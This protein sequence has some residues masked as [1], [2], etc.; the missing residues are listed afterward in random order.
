MPSTKIN[1]LFSGRTGGSYSAELRSA[2]AMG[3]IF[4]AESYPLAIK[5]CNKI[6]GLFCRDGVVFNGFNSDV[7]RFT[8]YSLLKFDVFAERFCRL[9]VTVMVEE[10][11]GE[12]AEYSYILEQN[13]AVIW[14]NVLIPLSDFKS[15]ARLSINDYNKI[16]ALRLFSDECF[17]INNF[18]VI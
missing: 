13:P 6:D 17:A 14:K 16:R 8:E 15:N 18:L 5:S 3:N 9:I 1:L 2:K 10:K 11:V 4:S 7:F 12:I